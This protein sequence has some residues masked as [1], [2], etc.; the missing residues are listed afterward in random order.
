MNLKKRRQ[1]ILFFR[2][3][4]H[5]VDVIIIILLPFPFALHFSLLLF[6]RPRLF[7]LFI[8]RRSFSAVRKQQTTQQATIKTTTNAPASNP[9]SR[10]V[11]PSNS[12][13]RLEPLSRL[14]PGGTRRQQRIHSGIFQDCWRCFPKST[15]PRRHRLRKNASR[16]RP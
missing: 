3:A 1:R 16:W 9:S 10:P 4:K 15:F 11:L 5:E 8:G 2:I 7:L 13:L 12:R 14:N 6:L